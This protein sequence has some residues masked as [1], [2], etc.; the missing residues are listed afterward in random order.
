MT[1]GLDWWEALGPSREPLL[2]SRSCWLLRV[3]G[4]CLLHPR[5]R[6]RDEAETASEGSLLCEVKASLLLLHSQR[7]TARSQAGPSPAHPLPSPRASPPIHCVRPPGCSPTTQG[8]EC[9]F[10]PLPPAVIP[11][12]EKSSCHQKLGIS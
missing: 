3:Q 2:P 8:P 11:T 1:Q 10:K 9:S 6:P 5:G 4:F 7:D 12:S